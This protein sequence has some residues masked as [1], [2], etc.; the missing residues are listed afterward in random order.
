MVEPEFRVCF[1]NSISVILLTLAPPA[2]NLAS[3]SP[4]LSQSTMEIRQENRRNVRCGGLEFSPA[5][6]EHSP[7]AACEMASTAAAQHRCVFVGNIPYDATEE[8]LIQICEEVGPV[9]SFRLVVDRETGKPRGYGFC[10]YKDEET[11]LSARR[12]LQGYEINGRQLRVDFAENDKGTDRNKEQGRGGPGLTS[13]NDGPKS[14]PSH[15]S[16]TDGSLYQPF[17]LQLSATAASVM[18][19]ALGG[20]QTGS[21]TQLISGI[22]SIPGAGSDPLTLYLAKMSRHQLNEIML[23]MKTLATNNKALAQQLLRGIPQ[24]P[25]ALFQAQIM[26][27]MVTPQMTQMASNQQTSS[28]AVHPSGLDQKPLAPFHQEKIALP[29]SSIF[30]RSLL[31][32]QPAPLQSQQPCFP[33]NR[34]PVPG[35][36][37][38]IGNALAQPNLHIAPLPTSLVLSQGLPPLMQ[39][40]RPVGATIIRH[41]PQVALPN[42]S[43]QQS[44]VPRYLTSQFASSNN[45]SLLSGLEKLSREPRPPVSGLDFIWA[46][47]TGTQ[48]NSSIGLVKPTDMASGETGLAIQLPKRQR[49]EEGGF[50]NQLT[51]GSTSVAASYLAESFDLGL[52][53]G[54]QTSTTDALQNVDKQMPQLSP[55]EE[56]ALMQQLMSLT[57]EQISSLP[58]EQQKQVLEIQLML[59]LK[60]P[61]I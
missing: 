43:L 35:T 26:L 5:A 38:G 24:L 34:I 40:S 3:P 25:K 39:H 36:M 60:H 37:S 10:E 2:P 52:S 41:P 54:K 31:P 50:A 29:D 56:S 44:L 32:P 49:L 42:T 8:Q 9:V 61:Q 6:K 16:V 22:P 11:A 13:S 21:Q 55:E 48:P 1:D 14:L 20:S 28:A 4:V 23:E 15:S 53:A 33:Q 51:G 18:A 27:G 12:N 17:G 46:S 57:P 59:R 58:S 47:K 7:A 45:P 30:Q 19:G